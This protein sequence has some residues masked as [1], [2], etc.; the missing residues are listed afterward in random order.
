MTVA[1]NIHIGNSITAQFN[2]HDYFSFHQFPV[3]PKYVILLLTQLYICNGG[4]I[5]TYVQCCYIG[6]IICLVEV[7]SEE[8]EGVGD[9]VIGGVEVSRKLCPV[10]S[11]CGIHQ[12]SNH[13]QHQL[14][15]PTSQS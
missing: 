15:I 11:S 3:H 7:A 6:V 2:N 5:L 13:L 8:I 1:C 12:I 9:D 14:S 10:L 4:V